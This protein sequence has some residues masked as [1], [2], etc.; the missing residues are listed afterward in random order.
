MDNAAQKPPARPSDPRLIQP[1]DDELVDN[2]GRNYGAA[3]APNPENTANIQRQFDEECWKIVE[4]MN[5]K[6]IDL[7]VDD[8]HSAFGNEMPQRLERFRAHLEKLNFRFETDCLD[9]PSMSGA[10]TTES[11]AKDEIKEMIKTDQAMGRDLDELFDMIEGRQVKDQF[12]CSDI[13]INHQWNNQQQQ[14]QA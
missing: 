11:M 12:K 8:N 6:F 3:A 13:I 1:E 9:L 2:S 4:E 10:S 14:F 7:C 5:E